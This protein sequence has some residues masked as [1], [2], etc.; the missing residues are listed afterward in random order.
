MVTVTG[1]SASTTGTDAYVAGVF[2]TGGTGVATLNLN[3]TTITAT[4]AGSGGLAANG[5]GST[6]TATGVTI[7]THGNYEA[8]NDFGPAGLTNQ[9]YPGSPGGGVVTLTN[10]SILTTGMQATGVYTADGGTTKLM[11]DSITTSGANSVGVEAGAGGSITL[12]GG[13]VATTGLEAAGVDA[14]G[15]GAVTISGTSVSTT[16]DASKGLLVLGAG[17][18]LTASNL[19]VTT[20]GTINAADGD[21]AYAVFNGSNTSGTYP[22][23]GAVTLTNLTI[24]TSGANSA[25]V[26]TDAS[27]KTTINGGSIATSGLNSLDLYATGSGS[28]IAANCVTLSTTGA[29]NS[30]TVVADHGAQITVIGG[31]ASTT[32]DSSYAAGVTAGGSLSLNGTTITATGLGSGGLFVNGTGGVLDATNLSVSTRGGID[33]STGDHADGA[34][35]GSYP[36]DPG[37]GTMTLTNLTIQTSGANAPGV[38]TE[39]GGLTKISGGSITTT[40]AGATGLAVNGIGSSTEASGVSITTQGGV[41]PATGDHA[42]GAFNGPYLPNGLT[43]GGVLSLTNTTIST[44]GAS[45]N[46]VVTAAGGITNISGSSVATS[47]RPGMFLLPS[48]FF[49]RRP[50]TVTYAGNAQHIRAQ[51]RRVVCIK[52]FFG[53]LPFFWE[54]FNVNV[55]SRGNPAQGSA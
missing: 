28:Q 42:D 17:S 13:S 44:S 8:V 39:D 23:G 5:T 24:Q 15:G 31:S 14:E 4:G 46:G 55:L 33:P 47:G 16:G 51:P 32:G 26:V 25:G 38:A 18:S 50:Q 7:T 10:S 35:N 2:T 41:N 22:Q 45:A 52:L 37:G 49:R 20:S 12:N 1:G 40:G 53:I 36:G 3:G 19:T 9:S 54:R 27:G 6:L 11:G 30:Q 43:S 29:P 21:H 34:F 48:K